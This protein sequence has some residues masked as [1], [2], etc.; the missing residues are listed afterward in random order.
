LKEER[1]A[2]LQMITQKAH[3]RVSAQL[4]LA[5]AKNIAEATSGD[6]DAD[7]DG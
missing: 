5:N 2:S 3:D 6:H 7:F 1:P 4:S